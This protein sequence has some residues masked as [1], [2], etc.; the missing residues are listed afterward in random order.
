MRKRGLDVASAREVKL[1]LCVV[2]S[3]LCLV[4]K[5]PVGLAG[6]VTLENILNRC[7]TCLVLR[8]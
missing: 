7:G 3:W 8:R 2:C 1:K 5:R 4:S 6:S